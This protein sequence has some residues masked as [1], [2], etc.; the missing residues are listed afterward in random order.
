M[1]RYLSLSLAFV[2]CSISLISFSQ[3]TSKVTS[4]DPGLLAIQ[5]AKVAKEYTI[6]S[7]KVTGLTTLDTAIVLSISGLQVGDKVMITG[8]DAF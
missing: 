7:I 3:D 5:N 2:F 1:Q 6:R 8:G 4:V